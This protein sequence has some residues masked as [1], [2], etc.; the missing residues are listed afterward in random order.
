[1]ARRQDPLRQPL[2]E[3]PLAGQA[4]PRVGTSSR[5]AGSNVLEDQPR[6]HHR[7]ARRD[8]RRPRSMLGGNNEERR[9]TDLS[10][11]ADLNYLEINAPPSPQGKQTDSSGRPTLGTSACARCR[12]P[13]FLE[14]ASSRR[15]PRMRKT[16]ASAASAG[17]PGLLLLELYHARDAT[18]SK[19]YSP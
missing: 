19:V 18:A 9:G 15:A 16:Q 10:A 11:T 8:T 3:R 14:A 5:T 1:M 2:G 4:P 13:T 6:A 7:A 12:P 17:W